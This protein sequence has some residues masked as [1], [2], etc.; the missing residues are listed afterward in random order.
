[1]ANYPPDYVALCHEVALVDLLYHLLDERVPED[2]PLDFV[3]IRS[4]LL[5]EERSQV[6]RSAM[7]QELERLLQRK[8]TLL[9]EIATYQ[10]VKGTP[11][12]DPPQCPPPPPED[13]EE[14]DPRDASEG[15]FRDEGGAGEDPF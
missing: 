15:D 11:L 10:V 14:Y 13:P 3:D 2:N 12:V 4:P 9:Q 5:P 8:K 1:M 6:P 7:L